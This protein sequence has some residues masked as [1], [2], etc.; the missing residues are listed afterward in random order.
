MK[1]RVTRRTMLKGVGTA[2]ALP[3]L[4]SLGFAAAPPAATAAA[5]VPRRVAFLYV[6][7]GVNMD[8]W[9]PAETGKLTKL[10]GILEPL[11][12]FKEHVNVLT[13][14]ALDK[15]RANGDGPGDHARAM[16]VFLTGRQPRKTS[17]ADIR[18]GMSA[19]QHIAAAVGDNTRFPSVELGIERG[20]QAGNCDSG[21]SCAYSSNLS[22]RGES[23]PNAKETDPKAVFE[24]LF[25][26][27]D[28][29][30]L[31]AARAKRELYS[32]SVLDFVAEDAN[33]LNKTLGQGDRR[34]L[35]E[36]LTSVR[37]VEQRI[38]K[39][40]QANSAPLPKTDMPAPAGTPKEVQDH[41]R[42]MCDLLVLTFQTD[43]TRVV[44]FPI[45]NDGSNRP[46]KMI[47][48]PEGHHD[49]SHHGS[50]PKKLE[51]IKKINTFHTEQLAYLVGKLKGVKEANG[52]SLLDNVMLVYGSGIGDGNRHNHDDLPVLLIG[53]GGGTVT[54][55]RHLTFPKKSDTPLMNLYLALFERMG[56]PTVRFGDS[57]GVLSI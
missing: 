48:V 9:T 39:A 5:G 17:G 31:A 25:G 32:K 27:N 7:N 33:Q 50:D 14:L 37:E 28:P 55:G 19:D 30:E 2:V 46:Y 15:A 20:Q 52:S 34:K 53:K 41:I 22:W 45:A 3:W 54:G 26:G 6:P 8:A 18:V 36:Y 16:S 24:R 47:D 23:T 29:K 51:K 40:R 21:Y 42:L 35:D 43:L 57:T 12:P 56:A 13:G 1:A 49:L 38:E 44:T 10:T 4:E 11:S